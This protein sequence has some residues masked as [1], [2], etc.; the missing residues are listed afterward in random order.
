VLGSGRRRR[1]RRRRRREEE[2]E[3]SLDPK[4]RHPFVDSDLS[5]INNIDRHS[6]VDSDLSLSHEWTFQ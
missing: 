5:F 1:R 4:K 6:F 2:E 3:F